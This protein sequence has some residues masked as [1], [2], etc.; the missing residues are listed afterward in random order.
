MPRVGH[1]RAFGIMCSVAAMAILFSLLVIHPFSWIPARA[2][3]GFCF[4]A[5]AMIVESWLNERAEASS[6]GRIFGAYTMVNLGATTAGQITL[7]LGDP[8]G[9][10]FFVVAAM[11]YC[12]ALLPTAVSAGASP[13]PLTQVSA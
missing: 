10:V 9:M 1:I 2:V 4:A 6:R 12:M 7:T 8:N 3:Q 13:K 11:V 5:A